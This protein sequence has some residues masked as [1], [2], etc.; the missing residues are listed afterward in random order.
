VTIDELIANFPELYHMAEESSWTNIQKHGLLSTSAILTL[1]GY[2]GTD[3]D[4]IESEWRP[5]KITISCNGLEDACIRDQIPMPPDVLERCLVGGITPKEWYRFINGKIFF[6]TTRKSLEIF[7]AAKEYKNMPQLV[8]TVDTQLLLERY[9]DKVTLSSINSGSTYYDPEKYDRPKS[10]GLHTF[11]RIQDY[12]LPYIA[13]L[14]VE[15]GVKDITNVALTVEKWIAHRINYEKP[16]FEK[17]ADI[18]S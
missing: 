5:K 2:S 4:K 11:K 1:Y 6:W 18:W 8:I 15:E 12:N 7:L 10:R 9:A 3:R 13:E 16:K 14:V 17:L